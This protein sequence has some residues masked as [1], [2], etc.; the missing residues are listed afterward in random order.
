M[1]DTHSVGSMRK[2]THA[3]TYSQE[4]GREGRGE[5][6][7]QVPGDFDNLL[8]DYLGT[9]CGTGICIFSLIKTNKQMQWDSYAIE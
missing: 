6:G 5:R 7:S 1:R 4:A 3:R 9:Y 8:L 2:H